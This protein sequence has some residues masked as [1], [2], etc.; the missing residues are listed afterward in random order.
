MDPWQLL[1]P[2]EIFSRVMQDCHYHA[3][4][5]RILAENKA[6]AVRRFKYR[7]SCPTDPY[8]LCLVFKVQ[9]NIAIKKTATEIQ[10]KKE[11]EFTSRYESTIDYY[12]NQR[13]NIP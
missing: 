12:C 6:V 3:D 10:V 13:Y 1:L 11:V 9:I 8:G 5:V 7:G 2:S 4:I